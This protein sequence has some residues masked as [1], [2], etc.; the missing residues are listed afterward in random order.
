MEGK[1]DFPSKKLCP[2]THMQFF[3][4]ETNVWRRGMVK[5]QEGMEGN[6]E[7]PGGNGGK[8]PPWQPPPPLYSA[9]KKFCLLMQHTQLF[10]K[11]I[12]QLFQLYIKGETHY[13]AYLE[14]ANTLDSLLRG[15]FY[16][17]CKGLQ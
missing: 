6:A 12:I 11:Y 10:R 13:T 5:Y 15:V 2:E 7:K 8:A 4:G 14:S 17:F 1:T 9:T 16:S 3:G